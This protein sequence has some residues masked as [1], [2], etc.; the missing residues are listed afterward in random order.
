VQRLSR[1]TLGLVALVCAVAGHALTSALLGA[2]PRLGW[3][4]LTLLLVA[5]VDLWLALRIRRAV[6]ENRV[7]QDHRQVHPLSVARGLALGQASA[8]LGAIGGGLGVGL[9]TFCATRLGDLA[10]AGEELPYAIG[11]A[12]SGGLLTAAGLFLEASCETPP[13][14][15]PDPAGAQPA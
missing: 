7:G 6:R 11:L 10:A 15:D 2:P 14:E 4:W 1:V 12:V 13:G 5:A 9:S 8:V 3:G